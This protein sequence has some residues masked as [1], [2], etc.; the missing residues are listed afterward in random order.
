M[1][2]VKPRIVIIG[3]GATGRGQIGQ[4]AHSAGW[5]VTYIERREDLVDCLAAARRFTVRLATSDVQEIEVTGFEVHHTDNV[6]AGAE[7]IAQ[8]DIVV[9]AVLP[10]NLESAVPTLASGLARRA[11]K[12]VE[13][14]LN[15]IA[16]ENMERSSSTLREYLRGGAPALDWAYIDTHVGFPDSMVARAVPVPKDDALV[17]LA[18]AT[19]EWSVDANAVREPM[20]RLEGMTLTANQDAALERKLYIKNTGHF[21]IAILGFV[22]GHRLMD[23]A[24]RD[25]EVFRWVDA[26]TRES[27]A[28]VVGRH[29]FDAA[30]TERYRASFL[31]AMRSPLLP[32]DVLRVIR[33]PLR[34]LTREERLVG[35]AMLACA[36]GQEPRA[37]AHLV[38]VTLVTPA[39]G[40]AQ[41]AKL[42]ARLASEGLDRVLATV[43]GIP[44]GHPLAKLV[45]EA[46]RKE[47]PRARAF[48]AVQER[49]NA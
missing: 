39:P 31:E 27:A 24:T 46:Y 47:S 22:R 49:G 7:A 44:H 45:A 35:P 14:P 41:S 2:A 28:A 12:Q 4:L 30:E 42:Q 19:Q 3:A 5:H 25:S 20:P 43:C 38:A 29:G 37:L 9:T 40:D 34:K 10:T 18:E 15:V 33:E 48:D 1:D 16:C 26:A 17:L 36:Q 6:E 21:A 32:D 11:S 13:K 23:E 8:A